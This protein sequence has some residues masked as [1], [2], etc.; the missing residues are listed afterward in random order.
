[1]AQPTIRLF[2][3]VQ[4]RQL[5]RSFT[6]TL[7]AILPAAYQGD[8]ITLVMEFMQA[9]GVSSAPYTGIDYSGVAV[10]VAVGFIG[11]QPRAG[12]FTITDTSASQ[13]TAALDYDTTA[14]QVQ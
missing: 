9:T 10:T 2:V 3:D 7:P 11:I 14:S 6:S 5:V 12:Q 13:T 1:M 4:N 8:T